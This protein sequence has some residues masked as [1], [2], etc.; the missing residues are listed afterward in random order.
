VAS[1]SQRL[2]AP[3]AIFISPDAIIDLPSKPVA[4]FGRFRQKKSRRIGKQSE[5]LGHFWRSRLDINF[6]RL[7]HHRQS[8]SV[9][10]MQQSPCLQLFSVLNLT[11]MKQYVIDELRPTDYEILKS[12][13]D[14][15]F[16]PPDLGGVYWIPLEQ[17]HL[18]DI[19]SSHGDCQPFYFA[20]ELQ[21]RSMAC[22]LLVRTRQ[23]VR[24]SCI[25]Y[26]TRPQRNWAIQ[27]IDDI[28]EKL[29]IQT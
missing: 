27:M 2:H 5:A 14:E 25:A 1:A 19:Q 16:G 17:R 21:E 15:R 9:S 12:F 11:V 29:N 6:N 18:S 26:A 22:E 28:F 24:C 23:R 7:A 3:S 4:A 10:G 20:V 8:T 13:L